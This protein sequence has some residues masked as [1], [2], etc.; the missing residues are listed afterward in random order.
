[1]DLK[2]DKSNS[3][4]ASEN[5]RI[6][7]QAGSTKGSNQGMGSESDSVGTKRIESIQLGDQPDAGLGTQEREEERM[8][9]GLG[10][11]VQNYIHALRQEIQEEE[12][13]CDWEEFSS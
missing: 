10:S 12:Q 7:F 2:Q 1:M 4:A 5:T 8:I 11:Q 13:V 9:A 3:R 6:E